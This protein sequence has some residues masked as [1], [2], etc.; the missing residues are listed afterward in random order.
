MT[1][2]LRLECVDQI[3]IFIAASLLQE[4]PWPHLSDADLHQGG[5]FHHRH[6]GAPQ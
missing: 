1:S 2:L 4:F 6:F 3:Y 5:G